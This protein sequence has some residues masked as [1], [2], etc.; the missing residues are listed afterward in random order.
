MNNIFNN[1]VTMADSYFSAYVKIIF[2]LGIFQL[3]IWI[4]CPILSHSI[5]VWFGIYLVCLFIFSV[6]SLFND[7]NVHI[8]DA[9][10]IM[11]STV[12]TIIYVIFI[13]LIIHMST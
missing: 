3:G 8:T 4:N 13:I 7:W 11:L 2:V 9:F 12:I 5:I 10:A 6:I 1:I